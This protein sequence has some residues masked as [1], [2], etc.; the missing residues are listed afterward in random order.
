MTKK[1]AMAGMIL[2]LILPSAAQAQAQPGPADPLWDL[3]KEGKFEEVAAKGKALL[4]TG[5][6]TAQVNLAVG[7]ALADLDRT[8]EAMP[9]LVRAARSDPG[10]TWVYAWAE[11]YLGLCQAKLGNLEQARKAFLLARDCGATA[12]ATRTAANNLR[13]LGLD[14]YFDDWTPF[15]TEHFSFRISPRLGVFDKVA[16]ARAKEQ[17]YTEISTWFGGG[18][19]RKIRYF[20]WADPSEA[21]VAGFPSLGFSKPAQYM[22]HAHAMQT[23]GHEITHVVSYHALMPVIKTGLIN[24][25]TA[26]VFDQT[27]R[28]TL[29]RARAAVA[30]GFAGASDPPF[31]QVGVRALWGDFDLLADEYSY[32]I[33]GAFVDRL[34]QKGGKEKFLD[35]F[36]DQTYAHAVMVY[37]P[38]LENWIDEFEGDLYDRD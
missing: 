4:N 32:P 31:V 20:V 22:I 15:E 38:G 29:A 25:G 16:F 19:D 8:E 37:G 24:E 6:D 14:E 11:V 1:L 3:Y 17:A 33:S 13:G 34:L 9:Y 35:F 28:D 2:V 30:Q 5:T 21:A 36:P 23:Q 18:P 12:N 27:G 10:K 7:R 26:V